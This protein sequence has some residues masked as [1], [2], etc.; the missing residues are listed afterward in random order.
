MVNVSETPVPVLNT[1][2]KLSSH[3]RSL[4]FSGNLG[5]ASWLSFWRI[6]IDVWKMILTFIVVHGGA[7][8]SWWA[9]FRSGVGKKKGVSWNVCHIQVR[10]RY[11]G[12]IWPQLSAASPTNRPQPKV[13]VTIVIIKLK[14]WPAAGCEAKVAAELSSRPLS[15]CCLDHIMMKYLPQEYSVYFP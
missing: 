6:S 1:W 9:Q 5:V 15:L 14:L 4:G 8:S 2:T 11:G 10:I 12:Q 3:G 13:I 7:P